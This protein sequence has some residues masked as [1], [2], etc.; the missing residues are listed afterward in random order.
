MFTRVF[1][2][3]LH[4]LESA[5]ATTLIVE[6]IM[7]L[8]KFARSFLISLVLTC[9]L[10][11]AIP[12][13]LFAQDDTQDVEALLDSTATAMSELES[14]HFIITTPVGKTL[15]VSEAELGT[16]E[17]DV[18]RPLAFRAL[19][20]I[21]L[22]F[23]SLDV[24]AVGIGNQIWVTNPLQGGEFIRLDD[25]LGEEIPPLTLLNPDQLIE[26]A[27]GLIEQ[28]SI[29]DVETLDGVEMT[30]VKGQFD[31]GDIT[32]NGTPVAEEVSGELDPLEITMWINNDNRVVQVEFSGALLP[33]E[34]GGGR[35]VRRIVLSQFNEVQPITPPA[36][37]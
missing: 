3:L 22:G 27:L 31:P 5:S 10:S 6:I 36:G 32:F 16:V 25:A 34:Q 15:L 30:V 28:A 24:E 14:F 1:T 7:N 26:Q 23:V 4:R 9:V 21:E 35:I 2:I 37:A 19:A 8:V 29:E 18:V 20:S 13:P 17:G 12:T 33:W 11:M